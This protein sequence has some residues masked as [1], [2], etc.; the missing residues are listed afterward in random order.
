LPLRAIADAASAFLEDHVPVIRL[1]KAVQMLASFPAL[2]PF[3]ATVEHTK[4]GCDVKKILLEAVQQ[5]QF[6]LLPFTFMWPFVV[7]QAYAWLDTNRKA[8]HTYGTGTGEGDVLGTWVDISTHYDKARHVKPKAE[9]LVTAPAS[10][11]TL[12]T[13]SVPVVRGRPSARRTTKPGRSAMPV[14]A[15]AEEGKQAQAQVLVLVQ[16]LVQVRVRVL[17]LVL[18]RV[19]V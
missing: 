18:V 5:Y 12:H 4:M 2:T 9:L 17:V 7:G 8:E 16:A 3:G 19:L 14:V 1:D 10:M 13:A 15:E 11:M 6:P